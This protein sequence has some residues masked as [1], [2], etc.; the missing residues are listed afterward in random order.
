MSWRWKLLFL[1]GV[2]E[3]V[4]GGAGWSEQSTPVPQKNQQEDEAILKDLEI[5]KDLEMLQ[6]LEI[7]QEM[8]VLRELDPSL[9]PG[10]QSEEGAR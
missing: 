1:L 3:A 4:T 6:M 5:V 7:L 10:S 8:E 9:P 2:L